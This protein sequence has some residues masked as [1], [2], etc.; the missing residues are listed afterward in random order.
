MLQW[1]ITEPANPDVFDYGMGNGTVS[2]QGGMNTAFR[3]LSLPYYYSRAGGAEI[4][5]LCQCQRFDFPH[6]HAPACDTLIKVEAIW[7]A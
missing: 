2:D 3:E 1:D 4:I 5:E 7:Q 6:Q